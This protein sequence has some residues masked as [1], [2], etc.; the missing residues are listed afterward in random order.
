[1][2][3]REA[4]APNGVLFRLARCPDPLAW[5]EWKYVGDQRFDDPFRLFRVLYVAEQR[6]ACFVESLASLR[7]P[8]DRLAR[9]GRRPRPRVPDEWI[10]IRCAGQLRLRSGQRW[11]DLRRL[12]TAEALRAEL[13]PLLRQLALPDLD[14]SVL[15]GP[16]RPLTRA[17]GRWAYDAGFQGI[18][19]RSRFHDG[20][21]CWAIFEGAEFD[22]VGASD[23]LARNDRDLRSA[24]ALFGLAV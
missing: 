8:L 9:G 21:D 13:A 1:M 12:E 2:T 18:A 3:I 19:Y 16:S 7:A 10:R 6:L 23:P 5:P 4:P 20:L 24:A 17:V 11:L 15:R 22:R 14:V